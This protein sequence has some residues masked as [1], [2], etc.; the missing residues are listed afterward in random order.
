MS[1]KPNIICF[2]C[3]WILRG[4]ADTTN[5]S[6]TQSFPNVHI[7]RVPCIGRIDPV[8]VLETFINGADGVLVLGCN[9]PDCHYAEG[10]LYAEKQVKILK[11]LLTL[12]SLE[13][14][15]LRLEWGSVAVPESIRFA[16]LIK[17]FNE[18]IKALGPSPVNGE[19]PE[20]NVLESLEAAKLAA[21]GFRL[22]VML[23]R[24]RE[25]VERGNVYHEEILQEDFDQKMDAVIRTE[26]LRYLIYLKVKNKSLSVKEISKLLDMDTQKVLRHI[27]VMRRKGMLA[28]D[29][30]EGTT[31]MYKALEAVI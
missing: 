27:V 8:I 2:M 29:R 10:N 1:F 25:L 16:Y 20:L 23:G 18:E 31:P 9:P 26:Y 11:K 22:R 13:R 19:N 28:V 5:A 21:E 30:V 3:N 12:T 4:K 15:R 14:K 17:D 24:E 7:V 6:R